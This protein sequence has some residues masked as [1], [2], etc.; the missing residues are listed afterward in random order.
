MSSSVFAKQDLKGG[1]IGEGTGGGCQVG[2]GGLG[3]M[4]KDNRLKNDLL[5]SAE[6][7]VDLTDPKNAF[8]VWSVAPSGSILCG[9]CS[10]LNDA[11]GLVRRHVQI[12]NMVILDARRQM[13]IRVPDEDRVTLPPSGR[14]V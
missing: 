14:G 11:F 4:E 7:Q 13:V 9:Q 10:Q 8:T 12:K 5:A 6:N 3:K 2:E 1:K